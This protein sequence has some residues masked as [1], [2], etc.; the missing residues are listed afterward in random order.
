MAKEIITEEL[1]GPDS[2]LIG[3]VILTG[4]DRPKI[5]TVFNSVEDAVVVKSLRLPNSLYEQA[6]KTN[7]PAGFSGVVRD[8]LA[9]YLKEP[10]Q[11]S[12]R[13]ALGVLEAA[14]VQKAA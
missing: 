11:E 13:H 1:V 14:L 2:P 5:G 7:H 6:L 12:V 8:A 9:A 3:A 10:D 4:E